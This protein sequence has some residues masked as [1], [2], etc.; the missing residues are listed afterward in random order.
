MKLI[1]KDKEIELR[2]A[3]LFAYLVAVVFGLPFGLI[4]LFSMWSWWVEAW[5]EVLNIPCWL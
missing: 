5:H 3:F 2:G 4:T 1:H